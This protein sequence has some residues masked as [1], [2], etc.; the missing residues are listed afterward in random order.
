[1]GFQISNKLSS[2]KKEK[3]KSSSISNS[4]SIKRKKKMLSKKEHYKTKK[5]KLIKWKLL[6][7]LK[8]KLK[9]IM[10]VKMRSHHSLRIL[11]QWE[12]FT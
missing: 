10:L 3:M 7:L 5:I 4:S 8:N 11:P 6:L 1:M 9:H 12:I 2:M